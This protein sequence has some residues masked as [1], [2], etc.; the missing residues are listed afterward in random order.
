MDQRQ[1]SA[2]LPHL[3]AIPDPRHARG[4]RY[5]WWVLLAMVCA[6]LLSGQAS[7]RPPTRSR[8][9]GLLYMLSRLWRA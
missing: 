6:A 5:A 2:L 1:Y 7:G 8:A 3:K 4:Q 9:S